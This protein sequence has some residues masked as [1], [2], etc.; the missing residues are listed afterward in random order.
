[1]H[2]HCEAHAERDYDMSRRSRTALKKDL[3]VQINLLVR[4]GC[5]FWACPGPNKP[6]RDMAT[7]IV[8][9]V[10]KD[11]RKIRDEI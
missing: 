4:V 8:C 10:I 11:L 3:Q 7:C 2:A 5:N 1:M 6:H 9:S